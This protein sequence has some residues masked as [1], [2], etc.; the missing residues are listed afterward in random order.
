M[1]PK[2]LP[3]I[4]AL[5]PTQNECIPAAKFVYLIEADVISLDKLPDDAFVVCQ[6]HHGDK[7]VYRA[8]I[9]LPSAA[10]SEKEGTYEKTEGCAQWTAPAVPT[11]GDARDD[12]K[13]VRTLSEVAGGPAIL[14]FH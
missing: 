14:R 7:G 4:L 11:V 13:I 2:L 5:Y 10:F 3:R 6:R 12:W 8:N 9:I 1:Q